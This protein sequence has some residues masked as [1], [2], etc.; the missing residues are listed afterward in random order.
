MGICTRASWIP[1]HLP[2]PRANPELE[3]RHEG[4]GEPPA[5]PKAARPQTP[6][7]RTH[8]HDLGATPET[9]GAVLGHWEGVSSP[10][11][12]TKRGTPSSAPPG[13]R[14]FGTTPN[15][16]SRP[17]SRC[18]STLRNSLTW[19]QEAEL[20]AN[21]SAPRWTW[22]STSA[23][24]TP[25]GSAAPTVH[26]ACA[27]TSQRHRPIRLPGGAS[28]GRRGTQRPA[29]PSKPSELHETKREDVELLD[30]A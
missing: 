5:D 12:A 21:G 10:A 16:S 15:T 8:G 18:E 1:G 22:P 11:A 28:R 26:T 23:T 20:P 6:V 17:S 13:S 25:R 27:S 24:R 3:T 29:I 19:D 30:A 2:R 4:E 14:F 7:P 9:R